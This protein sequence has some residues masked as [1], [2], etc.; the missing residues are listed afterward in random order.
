MFMTVFKVMQNPI[1]IYKILL[2]LS[3][4]INTQKSLFY[5]DKNNFLIVNK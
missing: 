1:K 4:M 3:L 5:G 2:S